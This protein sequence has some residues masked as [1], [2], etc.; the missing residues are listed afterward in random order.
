MFE[1]LHYNSIS[2][3]L[4]DRF[5]CKVVKLSLDAGLTCPNRDGTKGFGGCTFCSDSG[6]GDFA[7]TM[8]QQI[9]SLSRKWRSN[10]GVAPSLGT[11]S[12]EGSA[13]LKHIA[14]FQNHTNTYA[15]VE[16]LRALWDEA[17]DHENVV[18]LAIATRPDCLGP[19]VLDLLSE[20]NEK[21]FL[22]VELGLQ[23]ANEHT[24]EKFNRCWK[25][26]DFEQAMYDL[27]TRGIKRVTH[28]I[29]GLPGENKAQY[30]SS[31]KYAASFDPFGVK[32][33]MLHLMEGT[34][35]GGEYRRAPFPLL[36][37][38]EY[39]N[40]V[41]DILEILPQ[42]ITIHRLTGDAPQNK[43]I[44][45][46]WTRNKHAVLNAVQQEFKRRGTYQGARF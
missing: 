1:G 38:E 37:R 32:I 2:S 14:Y 17:L 33:H 35:M 8:E 27:S 42:S 40:C 25:N 26:A 30:L 29:L 46:D 36:T 34:V 16:K 7:G 39:V 15:P 18:G 45:P 13:D 10:S 44:A 21:T 41:C 24:A 11:R 12:K 19:D 5:G 4:K 3:Y 31:A 23:T 20:F 6:S 22:W 28:L 43:L 9:A